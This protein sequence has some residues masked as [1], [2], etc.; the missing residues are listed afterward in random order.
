MDLFFLPLN[1]STGS[2]VRLNVLVQP[3]CWLKVI[4]GL[5]EDVEPNG[6]GEFG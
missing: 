3:V 5:N 6:I 4:A 1:P 2:Q